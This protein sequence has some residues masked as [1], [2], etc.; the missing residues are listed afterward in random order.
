[1]KDVPCST[2]HRCRSDRDQGGVMTRLIDAT[3]H[4][5]PK[6]EV[7]TTAEDMQPSVEIHV[8]RAKGRWPRTT[9]PASS[10][11]STFLPRHAACLRS[12]SRST[13]SQRHRALCRPRSG[14]QQRAVDDHHRSV[15]A[16]QDDIARM[17]KDAEAHAEEDSSG[18]PSSSEKRCRHARVLDREVLREQG[19]KVSADEP[20]PSRPARRPQDGARAPMSTPSRPQPSA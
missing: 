4:P 12:R 2:S 5:H 3:H 17:V 14:D 16:Q 6:T 7:F 19:D 9:R 20:P 11:S 18:V 10:N 8:C 13:S 15:V 1:M